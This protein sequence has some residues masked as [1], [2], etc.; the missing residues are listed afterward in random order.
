MMLRS[1]V[2][3]VGLLTSEDENYADTVVE[4]SLEEE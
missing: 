2:F 1:K 3:S 4:D